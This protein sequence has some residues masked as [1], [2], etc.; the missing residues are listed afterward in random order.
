[1]RTIIRLITFIPYLIAVVFAY[2]VSFDW[3]INRFS[4]IQYVT[5]SLGITTGNWIILCGYC[6]W[7]FGTMEYVMGI[8]QPNTLLARL[9]FLFFDVLAIPLSIILSVLYNNTRNIGVANTDDVLNIFSLL[10]T[11][12]VVNLGF[13]FFLK[14]WRKQIGNK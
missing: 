1:M 14:M 10:I 9:T 8:L 13:V 7:T 2:L 6:I 4:T 11:S 5:Y 12:G 3:A